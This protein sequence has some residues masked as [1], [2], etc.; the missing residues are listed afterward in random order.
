MI[1][2]PLV[3]VPQNEVGSG[4]RVPTYAGICAILILGWSCS[5]KYRCCEIMIVPSTALLS[6]LQYALCLLCHIVPLAFVVVW[7]FNTDSLFRIE[8]SSLLFTEELLPC[9]INHCL[10]VVN[11]NSQPMKLYKHSPVHHILV[12]PWRCLTEYERHPECG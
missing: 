9:I 12:F 8:L 11:L 6:I 2:P 3:I 1:F 10:V 7:E 5:S 4:N